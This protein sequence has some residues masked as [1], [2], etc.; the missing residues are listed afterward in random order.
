MNSDINKEI[1]RLN[2]KLEE[3]EPKQRIEKVIEQKPNGYSITVSSKTKKTQ[4]EIDKD[5][6]ITLSS[7]LSE[8]PKKK[9]VEK[10]AQ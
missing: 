9:R 8:K 5:N 3:Y 1:E 2:N 10:K 6:G 7:D 4:V